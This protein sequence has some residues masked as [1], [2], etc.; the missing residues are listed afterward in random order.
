M[1]WS[2]S[3]GVRT[4]RGEP[5]S[6]Q[7]ARAPLLSTAYGCSRA[8]ATRAIRRVRAVTAK[9][10]ASMATAAM[11]VTVRELWK[12]Q[13]WSRAGRRARSRAIR[14]A[15]ARSMDTSSKYPARDSGF[16]AGPVQLRPGLPC[17]SP[18]LR[19]ERRP[20]RSAASISAS[21][22][23]CSRDRY[24]DPRISTDSS[25]DTACCSPRYLPLRSA[26]PRRLPTARAAALRTAADVRA[27]SC[28]LRIAL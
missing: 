27:C 6:S 21:A 23:A 25:I 26:A 15:G 4:E 2:D 28:R 18:H 12:L 16:A 14:R 20:H 7:V 22:G 8:I 3:R 13:T 11:Q 24:Q 9:A 19:S 5:G 1:L 10:A 17:R